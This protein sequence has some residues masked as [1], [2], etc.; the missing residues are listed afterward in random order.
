[1]PGNKSTKV[2]RKQQFLPGLCFNVRYLS[3]VMV[4][5]LK[6]IQGKLDKAHAM[7]QAISEN[8]GKLAG[9]EGLANEEALR[10]RIRGKR[11]N[12]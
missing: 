2:S 6:D 1:M 4:A 8:L 9:R 5:E 3:K 10:L 11:L 12:L 7:L